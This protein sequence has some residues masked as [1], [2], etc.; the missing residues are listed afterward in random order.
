MGTDP[1]E[2]VAL[3]INN[4]IINVIDRKSLYRVAP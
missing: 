1:N 3:L 2:M 4:H